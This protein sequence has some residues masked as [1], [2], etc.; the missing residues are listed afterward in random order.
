[1]SMK[2]LQRLID[3]AS[4]AHSEAYR[5]TAAL[6]DFCESKYGFAPSDIDADQIIDAVLGGCGDPQGMSSEE[7]DR[8]M[9]GG[10]EP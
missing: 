8:I 6:N 3:R 2:K 9:R 7:F 10:T 5:A 4:R 1:M